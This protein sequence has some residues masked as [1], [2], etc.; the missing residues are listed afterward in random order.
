M[1]TGYTN[2]LIFA[3][4]Y[5]HQVS[6]FSSFFSYSVLYSK[7]STYNIPRKCELWN[8][9]LCAV[10]GCRDGK[11]SVKLFVDIDRSG[12]ISGD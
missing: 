6:H 8:Q 7:F 5:F 9:R 10:S 1:Y 3:A 11:V 4:P 2:K 12:V